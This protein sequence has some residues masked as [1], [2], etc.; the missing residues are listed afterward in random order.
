LISV[1]LAQGNLSEAVRQYSN[2]R[3]LMRDELD[4]EPST[5]MQELL[6]S[7]LMRSADQYARAR[8]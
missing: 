1:H 3:Q 4:L 7:P 5:Q 8:H 2:Y 6:G